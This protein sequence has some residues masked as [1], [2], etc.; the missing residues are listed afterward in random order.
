MSEAPTAYVAQHDVRDALWS[1]GVAE[2]GQ[3]SDGQNVYR[4][5]GQLHVGL[6]DKK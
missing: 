2:M 1:R 4:F 6:P 3:G 5:P